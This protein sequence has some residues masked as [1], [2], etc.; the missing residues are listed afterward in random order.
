[1]K[2][3]GAE[4]STFHL[5]IV[6]TEPDPECGQAVMVSVTTKRDRSDTTVVVTPKDH[7]WVRHDS[8][9]SFAD[10]MFADV[11][12]VEGEMRRFPDDYS[13]QN[14]CSSQFMRR[15][16]EGLLKSRMTPNKISSHC[17]RA[18]GGDEP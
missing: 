1:M 15:I 13:V 2:T 8:V 7:P 9:I 11:R 16:R 14:P 6:V 5:W 4:R 18:W 12:K 17:R 10:A 3:P